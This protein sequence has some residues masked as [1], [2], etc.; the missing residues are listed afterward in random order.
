MNDF[1]QNAHAELINHGI[2]A[3]LPLLTTGEIVRTGTESKPRSKNGYYVTLGYDSNFPVLVGGDWQTGE[4]FKFTCKQERNFTQAEREAYKKAIQEAES[5][6]KAKKEAEQKKASAKAQNLLSKTK[7]ADPQH[8]YL[9]KKGITPLGTA[10]QLGKAL[11]IPLIDENKNV[12][13]LQFIDELGN[14]RFIKGGKIQSCFSYINGSQETILICEGYAT[15]AS[16]NLATDFQVFIS[17]SANNLKAVAKIIRNKFPNSKIIICCD[18][19]ASGTGQKEAEKASRAINASF[20][21]PDIVGHDFNDIHQAKG[22]EAVKDCIL[23]RV[24]EQKKSELKIINIFDLVQTQMPPLEFI[25][26][27]IINER[28]LNMIYAN[29]GVGKT[30]VGLELA[31]VVA[32][33]STLFGR[34]TAEKPR[35]VLYLDGEMTIQNIQERLCHIISRHNAEPPDADY[36]RI[37]TPDLQGDDPMPNFATEEG[38]RLL[39]PHLEGIEFLVIDNIVT[40]C[41]SKR[42][43]EE[44]SWLPIQEWALRLR[45]K[46]TAVLFI[47]HTSKGGQ[48]RGTSAKED[49]LD[50]VIKLEHPKDYTME[51]GTCFEVHYT[52]ARNFFG[53]DAESFEARLNNNAKLWEVTPVET[54]NADKVREL[55]ESGFSQIEIANELGVTKGRVSQIFK[56]LGIEKKKKFNV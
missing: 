29:R 30:H 14:K 35:K 10:K 38:Q 12:S 48:Q 28:S 27:P 13:S 18:N 37:L 56:E 6:R 41:R 53:S 8:P 5:K 31:Y 51:L 44:D 24:K 1:I 7:Q 17:F 34:W 42:P 16:L 52:K 26:R 23:N 50:T 45:R 46:G 36:F 11:A 47:H 2:L 43:N 4:T 20:V 55:A 49:I 33:G 3:D 9:I 19:D 32:T 39:E 40:L 15:G 22:L 21:M 25:V 54:K